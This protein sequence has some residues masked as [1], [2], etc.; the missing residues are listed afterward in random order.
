MKFNKTIT[1][2]GLRVI[3][4]PMKENPAVTVLVM[5]EAGSKY[6]TEEISG[7]SHF[8]EHMC[9]K[10]TRKRPKAVDISREL[11]KIG[12][13]Y[14]AF[15]AQEFTGYYAKSSPLHFDVILDVVS[16]MYLNPVFE[17]TEIEKEKGV[18][19]EEINMYEDMPHRHVH[20]LF[21]ELLYGG[22]PAGWNIAGTRETVKKLKRD[23]FVDY[24]TKHYVSGATVVV[25]VGTFNEKDILEKI[26]K[27]FEGIHEGE[28]HAKTKVIEKQSEPQL[29]VKFKKTDQ[30]HLVLGVRSFDIFSKYSHAIKV[31]SSI[32]GGGMSS[33]LFQ[34]LRDEMGVGYYVNA[35]NDSYTDHGVF[36][37]STGVDSTRVKEVIKA[38]IDEF[39]KLKEDTV[40]QEELQKAKDYIIGNMLLGLESSDSQAE[41]CGY[42]EILKKE[43]M[44]PDEIAQ[45]IQ[46]VTS[47]DI[48]SL[49]NMIF[50]DQNLNMA[51]IGR[52]KSGNVFKPLLKLE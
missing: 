12:A 44:T 6:E 20:D 42:Q 5:V 7:V 23:D 15:T 2:N 40:P 50:T 8:L 37:V 21:M 14:N 48:K 46:A 22:Q 47:D 3:T 28:K 27:K 11:D 51:L 43:I 41:F 16:D 25:V 39:K 36:S 1:K 17:T 32:L 4:L 26:E 33:R 10:G 31:M 49:A 38:I 52:F 24:R 30:T 29:L 13:Q 35:S 45:K 19:V 18:I 34:K 9:F